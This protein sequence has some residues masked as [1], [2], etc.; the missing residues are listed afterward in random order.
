VLWAMGIDAHSEKSAAG[1]AGEAAVG[2]LSNKHFQQ[3]M[4]VGEAHGDR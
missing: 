1:V 4:I 3:Y 2:L